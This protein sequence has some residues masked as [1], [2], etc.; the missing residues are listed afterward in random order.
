MSE[1]DGSIMGRKRTISRIMLFALIIFMSGFMVR[2]IL[3]YHSYLIA[4]QEKEFLRLARSVK[5][6]VSEMM[7]EE[8]SAA[9]VLASQIMENRDRAGELMGRYLEQRNGRCSQAMLVNRDGMV[10]YDLVTPG[11]KAYFQGKQMP[12]KGEVPLSEGEGVH[13]ARAYYSGDHSYLVPYICGIQDPETYLVLMMNLD[14]MSAYLNTV[15]A[16]EEKSYVALKTQDGYILSHKNPEQIGLHMVEGRKEKYP[17][18]DFTDYERIMEMQTTGEEATA[19]YSSYWLDSEPVV[20]AKKIAS[21]TPIWLDDEFWIVT[22]NLNYETYMGPLRRYMFTSLG[23]V[24]AIL[25]GSAFMIL[26]YREMQA[27]EK[28]LELENEY[29][30]ELGRSRELLQ[31]EREQKIRAMKTAR[32]GLMTNKISHQ[33]RNFLIPILGYAEFIHDNEELPEEVRE[34]AGSI[35]DYAEKANELTVRLS[36]M[37]RSEISEDVKREADLTEQL[38]Q[39]LAALA[40]SLPENIVL[41]EDTDDAP[42]VTRLNQS[43]IQDVFWN[44]AKNAFDAMKDGG[45]LTVSSRQAGY[46]E[47]PQNAAPAPAERYLNICFEDTGCGMDEETRNSIFTTWFTTK[48]AGEGTGLGLS[49]VYDTVSEMGGDVLVDSE[50]GKGT[51]F[52]ICF[53][54]MNKNN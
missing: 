11:K 41:Q 49:V 25:A 22:L 18:L 21:F 51:K 54:L 48:P 42:A 53:P 35:L 17:D 46:R 12:W 34:D 28:E 40:K 33:F 4:Q 50:P 1:K 27:K 14:D 2:N 31:K 45:T 47:L 19:V 52:T 26:K 8:R 20:K 43:G 36:R 37:S 13:I 32:L 9:S 16:D 3:S 39:F 23:L 29:L 15:L 44:I 10:L 24:A 30:S 38:K 5:Y 7:E 6:S